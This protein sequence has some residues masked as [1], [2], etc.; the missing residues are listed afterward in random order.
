MGRVR[1]EDSEVCT[2]GRDAAVQYSQRNKK[3]R[4]M[5][6]ADYREYLSSKLW[7]TIRVRVMRRDG[8]RCRMCQAEATEVHHLRYT[9]R[10]LDGRGDKHLMALC[11]ACH[12]QAE[13]RGEEKVSPSEARNRVL[14]AIAAKANPKPKAKPPKPPRA[15]Q[16]PSK[17]VKKA[18]PKPDTLPIF[19]RAIATDRL[20]HQVPMP[21]V[22]SP[23]A[24]L[25]KPQ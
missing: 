8:G 6:F 5:G 3:I 16:K 22:Q 25:R 1:T 12:E 19:H 24:R 14:R 11:R 15:K 17:K 23:L 9:Q 4:A 21:A 2:V 20:P 13:F 18:K 10:V 7:H